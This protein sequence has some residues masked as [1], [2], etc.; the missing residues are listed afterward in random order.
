L[1]QLPPIPG[2]QRAAFTP[3]AVPP[4]RLVG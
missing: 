2:K 3:T 1:E 4:P